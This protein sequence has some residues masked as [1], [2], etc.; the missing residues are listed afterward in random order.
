MTAL[1]LLLDLAAGSERVPVRLS[2]S[3][4][5]ATVVDR[6]SLHAWVTSW[7]VGTY[8][9]HAGTAAH[10]VA[11]RGAAGLDEMPAERAAAVVDEPIGPSESRWRS[12]V[13]SWTT[14]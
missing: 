1:R 3:S 7:L 14:G 5:A 13:T 12:T 11:R 9:V 4:F 6:E 2:L 8:Q 10:L